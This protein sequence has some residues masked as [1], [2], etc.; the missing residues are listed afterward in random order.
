MS[1]EERAKLRERM[2]KMT[3]E[4]REAMRRRFR[5]QGQRGGQGR[6]RSDAQGR[7]E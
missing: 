2:E 3:P 6:P 4:E 5:E 7:Q 1:P